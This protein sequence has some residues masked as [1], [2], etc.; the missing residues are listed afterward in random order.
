MFLQGILPLTEP[1]AA[2]PLLWSKEIFLQNDN[3][4]KLA[5]E[6]QN[7][8]SEKEKQDWKFNYCWFDKKR[9]LW[10]EPNNNAVLPETLKCSLL[11][12]VRALNH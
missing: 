12:T 3:L 7:L 6:A 9:R 11:T 8:A 4:E 5:I 10:F 2:K 1:E